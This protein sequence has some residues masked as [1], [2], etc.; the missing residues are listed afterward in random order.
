MGG[1][2]DRIE[3][4]APDSTRRG[5]HPVL[6]GV[7]PGASGPG[8]EVGV[9][10]PSVVPPVSESPAVGRFVLFE[11]RNDHAFQDVRGECLAINSFLSVLDEDHPLLV[12]S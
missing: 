2:P 1:A 5:R 3:P 8:A 10:T 11:T 7:R 9:R 12:W 4:Q 6:G